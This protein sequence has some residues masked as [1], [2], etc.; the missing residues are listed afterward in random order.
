MNG[1]ERVGAMTD[2][3]RTSVIDAIMDRTSEWSEAN[4]KRDSGAVL[5]LFDESV[6]MRHVENGVIFDSY[7]AVGDFIKGW[8][9]TT[10]DMK[11]T[12]EERRV[13]PLSLEVA[14]MTGIFSYE[15][16]QESG[17]FFQG[18]NVFTGVFVKRG[19]EWRL[20]NGHESSVP[21]EQSP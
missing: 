13:L 20:I 18:R 3:Q 21:P 15:A 8:Y 7:K 16:Q 5:A 12:W 17:K 6:E 10:K 19:S 2:K 1:Q 4:R 14:T 11:H 9:E